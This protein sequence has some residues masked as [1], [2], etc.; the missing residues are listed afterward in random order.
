[1]KK[2]VREGKRT[3]HIKK[4]NYCHTI[5][6]SRQFVS[7]RCQ[8]VAIKSYYLQ[9]R[10]RKSTYIRTRDDAVGSDVAVKNISKTLLPQ[11]KNPYLKCTTSRQHYRGSA[12]GGGVGQCSFQLC[13]S[14]FIQQMAHKPENDGNFHIKSNLFCFF[15][16]K[17][18][19][20]AN[21]MYLNSLY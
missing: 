11:K 13:E 1:M 7:F 6:I 5:E 4:T 3:S 10:F 18:Q 20:K 9:R 14:K 17:T 8:Y 15:F 2:Y 16:V 21:F 12:A 19:N